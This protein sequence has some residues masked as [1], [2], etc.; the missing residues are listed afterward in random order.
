MSTNVIQNT[1]DAEQIVANQIHILDASKM[2]LVD[3]NLVDEKGGRESLYSR[4][5][6]EPE[7]PVTLRVGHYPNGKT[8]SEAVFNSSLKLTYWNKYTDDDS[9]I[10]W[11][12]NTVVV[13]FTTKRQP[14]LDVADGMAKLMGNVF[15]LLMGNIT[16]GAPDWDGLTRL[17]RGITDL[18]LAD[19]VRSET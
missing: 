2:T 3:T 15:S 4:I 13:A 7:H 9:V 6:A 1:D 14:L 8:G 5:D 12:E 16:V 19:L 10:F 11:E 17:S 18:D